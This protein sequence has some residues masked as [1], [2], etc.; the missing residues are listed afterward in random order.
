[1]L[2]KR[3][4]ASGNEIAIDA[5]FFFLA[6]GKKGSAGRVYHKGNDKKKLQVKVIHY[7]FIH[8]LGYVRH[9]N[10]RSDRNVDNQAK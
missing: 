3:I 9:L 2:I 4:A 5:V 1:M 6:E 7:Y 8:S 10:D